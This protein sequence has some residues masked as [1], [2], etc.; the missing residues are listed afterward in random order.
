MATTIRARSISR[1]IVMR[2]RANLLLNTR[3][4]R[5]LES[6]PV[7]CIDIGAR[8]GFETDLLP[9]A[10]AVDAVGMEPDPIAFAMLPDSREVPWRSLRHLPCA[11]AGTPGWRTLSIPRHNASASLLEHDPAFGVVFKKTQYFEIER[12][13][14]IETVTLD[15]ALRTAGLAGPSYLKLDVEGAELEIL[16]GAPDSVASL[17]AAKVEVSFL[18]FRKGQPVAGDID[19]LFRKRGFQLMDI[20]KP[21]HWR[22]DGDVV[23]PHADRQRIP[24]SRGQLIQADFLYFRAPEDIEGDDRLVKAAGLA[25]TYG[26]FD[27]ALGLLERLR[28]QALP[29]ISAAAL[30]G[31]ASRRYGLSVWRTAATDHFK[32]IWTYGRSLRNLIG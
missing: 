21:T 16:E 1:G 27:H 4:G 26:F 22:T 31:E 32:R 29:G 11:I 19:A 24:Y 15:A 18:P 20:I 25:A 9:I 10:S 7:L 5:L 12:R 13:E 14:Q 28:I 8:G 23:H 2:N 3:L 30:V 17:L 6:H